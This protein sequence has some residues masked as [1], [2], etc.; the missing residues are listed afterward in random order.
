MFD[1]I[2]ATDSNNGIGLEGKLPWQ[3][4]EE[5]EIF[6]E[7]T[8]NAI[9]IVG[10]KTAET[11][12]RLPNRTVYALSRSIT[13]IRGCE[14]VFRS[15]SDALEYAESQSKH[16]FIAGGANLYEQ[17]FK[18]HRDGIH[19]VHMSIMKDT[20]QCDTFFTMDR[21]GMVIIDTQDFE[22]FTH[23]TFIYQGP[24][25]P[26]WQYLNLLR[27]VTTNGK[28]RI[29]RNGNTLSY[30]SPPVLDIDLREGFPL[31]T[32]KRMFY[33][34]IIEELLFFLRGDTDSKILEK[35]NVNIW[36]GN[37]SRE[38][39]DSIDKKDRKEGMLGPCYGF[40]FRSFNA[41]YNEETGLPTNNETGTDQFANVV[42]LIKNDPHSRR[43]LM[44][45]YNPAQAPDG[46]LYPCHSIAL[47]FYVD[48][49]YLDM[50]CFNRSSDLFLGLPFNIAS[51]ALL[52]SI[53][54]KLTRTI[55]RRLTL[56]L[57]DAHIYDSHLESVYEQLKRTPYSLPFLHI[58]H[59]LDSIE[60]IGSLTDKHFV[61]QNYRYHQRIMAPMVP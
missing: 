41:P 23:F 30:F 53:V 6:K 61:I 55:P 24:K 20:Y 33:R 39:L 58:D 35:K 25:Q 49:K 15:L 11:L 1:I 34:G 2:L 51:S 60:D 4:Q 19:E 16:I 18:D 26:E 37:T 9:L 40:Q 52:L 36:K 22:S 32:S 38:F 42:S 57:G 12:P 50:H 8:Q 28:L 43:I 45:S 31:L 21:T 46:V 44:T 56:A 7:K 14:H 13:D 27:Y 5:L 54:A 10:R 17:A 47:Q 3:C 59:N 48:D 29:G